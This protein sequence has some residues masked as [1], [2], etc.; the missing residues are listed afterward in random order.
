MS[1]VISANATPRLLIPGIINLFGMHYKQ[2]KSVF[3]KIYEKK[4]SQ[5]NFEEAVLL[6][7]LGVANRKGEGEAI[8]LDSYKQGASRRTTH[9]VWG[10]AMKVTKEQ[11]DDNKHMNVAQT[12]SKELAK[13]LFHAK[14]INAAALFNNCTSTSAPYVGWD[15][16]AVLDTAHPTGVGGT[17]TNKASTDLSELALEQAVIDIMGWIGY[18]G[19]RILVDSSNLKLLV[20]RQEIFNIHRILK[21]ELRSGTAENDTNALK[22]MG[23][24]SSIIPWV[25]L[26]DADAWF[27]ITGE[28]GLCY[29]DRHSPQ[30]HNYMEDT[31]M[32]Q[33]YQIYER[34]SFDHY[35][36]HALY[37]SA[38]A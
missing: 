20:P 32:D 9:T 8:A 21:S 24:V 7:G 19:L 6:Q 10:K 16:K 3:D 26:S 29:Y 28:R 30:I 17:Y 38:G 15:G 13:S 36:N 34:Y 22:D 5:Q 1:G 27:I 14:E 31:T 25:F 4:S 37:G 33:V 2:H 35:D 11:F 18:D 12:A 23:I